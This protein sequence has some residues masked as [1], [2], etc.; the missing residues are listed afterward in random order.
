MEIEI[1]ASL[2][3]LCLFL[4]QKTWKHRIVTCEIYCAI[5]AYNLSVFMLDLLQVVIE[6]WHCKRGGEGIDEGVAFYEIILG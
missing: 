6:E 2:C 3:C 4:I 5:A 1:T